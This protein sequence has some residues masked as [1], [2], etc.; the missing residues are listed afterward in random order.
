MSRKIY[1]GNL[2]YQ[3]TEETLNSVFSQYGEVVSAVIIKDRFTEQSK[4]FGFIEMADDNA[5][6]LAVATMNGKDLDGRRIRVNIA[7]DKPQ[8][9][10]REGFNRSGRNFRDYNSE[11]GRNREGRFNRSGSKRYNSR[12]SYNRDGY[13]KDYTY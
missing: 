6:D 4:G 10:R 8:R 9:P 7:E 1:V 11:D 2:N 3:T 13:S 5:I 12:D